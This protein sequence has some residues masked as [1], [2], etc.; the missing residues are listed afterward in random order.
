MFKKVLAMVL[1]LTMAAA[2][3][4]GCGS[5][6][7]TE[8]GTPEN[9]DSS[10]APA[11][12]EV[13]LNIFQF[14]VE[15][16]EALEKSMATYMESH[17]NVKI[18][19]KTVGGGDDYGAALKAEMQS[20]EPTIFNCGGPQDIYDWQEKLEDLSAEPWVSK[21][22]EGTL[23]G[24]TV[25]GKVYGMPYA[26]EGY[27]FTCNKEIMEAA[28]VDISK[29]N[30]YDA[31]EAACKTIDAKIKDGSLK[32][33]Y[34]DLKAV[35]ALPAKETWIVG[36]HAVNVPLSQ[37][38]DSVLDAFSAKTV[39]FKYADGYKALIDLQ[40]NYSEYANDKGKLN[41]MDY[42]TQVKEDFSLE[43]VVMIQQGNWIYNDVN[44]MD[45]EV[46]QKLDILPMPIKGAKEDSI[47]VGVPNYWVIN[48]DSTD[49]QKA[50]AKDF[51]NWLY[52]S[53]EGMNIVVN[54]FFFI[55]PFTGYTAEPA[56]PLGKAVKRY[57]DAGKTLPWVFQGCPTGNWVMDVMGTNVQKYLAGEF[58]W[59]QTIDDA[60]AQWEQRRK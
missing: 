60:K 59:Q 30:S 3:F 40:A 53:E 6:P 41:A 38:F 18:N 21:A 42:S 35:F 13:T 36:T 25:D 43:K 9:G 24:V 29:I 44:S 54:E 2:L 57:A 33:K 5:T 14:K 39:D 50:T 4:T 19:L 32:E 55:P 48:K 45:P 1:S 51:L 17:P 56:D 7:K 23:G 58:T 10:A 15:I 22:V 34:P 47:P 27:G 46:A 16:Q 20:E 26:I 8:A 12:E 31:L 11:A 52:T 49:A 28:G 37:E